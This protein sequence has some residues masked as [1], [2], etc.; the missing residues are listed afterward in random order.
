MSPEQLVGTPAD[1]RSDLWSLGVM[2]IEML[3]GRHP[4]NVDDLSTTLARQIEAR[5]RDLIRPVSTTALVRLIERLI[6][7]D[8]DER[9]QSAAEVADDISK[10]G[11]RPT[12]GISAMARL[13]DAPVK[14][15]ALGIGTAALAVAGVLGIAR[16]ANRARSADA[17]GALASAGTLQTHSLAVLPFRNYGGPDQEYFADGMTEELTSTLTKIEAIRVIAHQSVLQFKQSTRPA[18]EIAAKLN[19]KYLL[20]GAVRQDSAHITDDGEPDRRRAKH[21]GVE[22]RLRA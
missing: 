5:N 1:A 19:V 16:W 17:A 22:R 14:R 10:L 2:L 8:P 21:P 4:S 18:S 11:Q 3:T 9:Y 13:A 15:I 6:R 7:R 12:A 20:D